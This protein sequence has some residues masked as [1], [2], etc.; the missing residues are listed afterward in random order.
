VQRVCKEP[1]HNGEGAKYHEVK[2][3][4]KRAGHHVPETFCELD[5]AFHGRGGDTGFAAQSGLGRTRAGGEGLPIRLP[6]GRHP[7]EIGAGEYTDL[8]RLVKGA[9]CGQLRTF[10]PSMGQG[11]A[12]TVV[13][14][15]PRLFRYGRKGRQRAIIGY[16][17]T[18][19][20]L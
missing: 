10:R 4:Q 11:A 7:V 6:T 18:K 8:Y 9:A 3:S 19:G 5:Q 2:D 1:V 14:A 20:P 13:A 15:A 12:A 17:T 16:W